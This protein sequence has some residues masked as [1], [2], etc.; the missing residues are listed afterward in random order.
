MI[1]DIPGQ[2]QDKTEPNNLLKDENQAL[3]VNKILLTRKHDGHHDRFA[4][5]N[6]QWDLVRACE[7]E[8]NG[9]RHVLWSPAVYFKSWNNSHLILIFILFPDKGHNS[10]FS[11]N[12]N[13]FPLKNSR[14]KIMPENDDF[15]ICELKQLRNALRKDVPRLK[16]RK[17]LFTCCWALHLSHD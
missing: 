15:I 11:N 8:G 5:L 4:V 7:L 3:C 14:K 2:A 17:R 13:F 1:E 12:W 6:G 16:R 9:V 10:R